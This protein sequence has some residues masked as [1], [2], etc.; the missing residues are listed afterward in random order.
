M[1]PTRCLPWEA[2]GGALWGVSAC[3]G[4]TAA[5]SSGVTSQP[6][7]VSPANVPMAPGPDPSPMAEATG[8]AHGGSCMKR[9]SQSQRLIYAGA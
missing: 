5:V 3:F 6:H 2:W 4:A 1:E 7:G 9:S 8:V